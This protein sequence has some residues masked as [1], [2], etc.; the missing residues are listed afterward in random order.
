M[1][2]ILMKEFGG[3]DVLYLGEHPDPVV[4]EGELL[5]RVRATAL[6]RA[7]LLQRRGLYPPPE[8][9]PNILGLEMAGDVVE[10]GPDVTGWSQGDRVCALL[11]GGGYAEYVSIPAEMAMRLPDSFG[12]EEG[13]AIPEVFLTA[14]SNLFWLGNL[15]PGQMV[16][17]HAGAS[18]VG[19][20]AIQLIRESGANTLVTA[21]SQEKIDFCKELGALAGWNYREGSFAPWVKE[22][23]DGKGVNLIL[24]FVGAPYFADNVRS[25]AVDGR[26]IVIGT[27]GGSKVDGVNLADILSR[28]LQIIGTA[29]R[30]RNVAEKIRLTQEFSAF[31]LPRFSD[32]RLRP[33]IDSV[34][35]WHE[36]AKAHEYMESNRNIGKIVLRVTE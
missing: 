29:L 6:N 35:D 8:G 12:Y 22:Q 17:T 34:Y 20:A 13:A 16:L 9:T 23:T 32:A 14:Y 7:D 28:R 33:I 36:V 4:G 31:A 3:T 24:D 21:G 30:T 10:V 5:V 26:L 2:A 15:K 1:K 11:P 25:L 19:T 18:G 27:M